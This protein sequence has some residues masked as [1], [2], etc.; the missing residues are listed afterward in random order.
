MKRQSSRSGFTLIE[1]LVVLGIIALLAAILFPVLARAKGAARKTQCLGNQHQIHLATTL[2]MGDFDQTYPFARSDLSDDPG[3][4]GSSQD[5][6]WFFEIQQYLKNLEIF[7]DAEAPEL[8]KT[9]Y[10]LKGGHEITFPERSLGVNEILAHH[11]YTE[12]A[13]SKPSE[14]FELGYATFMMVGRPGYVVAASYVWPAGS[15][16]SDSL[17]RDPKFAQ[18]IHD[19]RFARH[20]GGDNVTYCD[21]HSKWGA[22]GA[23]GPQG[24]VNPLIDSV[25]GLKMDPQNL[26]IT[27]H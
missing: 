24:N 1:L 14:L 15:P 25:Y 11:P 5:C 6:S 20:A 7:N 9:E 22:M 10:I 18:I 4:S 16:D 23:L 27:V 21:G 2:Y 26:D 3:L 19:P 13:I 17:Y 12:S 8:D